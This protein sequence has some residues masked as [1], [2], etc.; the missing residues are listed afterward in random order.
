MNKTITFYEGKTTKLLNLFHWIVTKNHELG[1]SRIDAFILIW[2]SARANHVS[3]VSSEVIR[4]NQTLFIRMA[5]KMMRRTKS[6]K[7]SKKKK[8]VAVLLHFYV[9]TKRNKIIGNHLLLYA[10]GS[11]SG[12]MNEWTEW[13]CN[14]SQ[15]MNFYVRMSYV[16]ISFE[17]NLLL[18]CSTWEL[19]A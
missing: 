16:W 10:F 6:T 1:V 18:S 7:E 19:T 8:R 14:G 4:Q 13:N 5:R 11:Y 17:H 3:R 12:L 15:F 2:N 9:S